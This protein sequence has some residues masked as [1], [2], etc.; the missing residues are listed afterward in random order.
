MKFEQN[1]IVASVS[2]ELSLK[3]FVVQAWSFT[4]FIHNIQY[5]LYAA[6]SSITKRDDKVK[7]GKSLA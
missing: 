7:D 3:R 5:I 2:E 1:P 4:S 6:W